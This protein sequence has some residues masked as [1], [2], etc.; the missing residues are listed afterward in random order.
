MARLPIPGSDD[1]TW[2]AILNDYLTVAHDADGTLKASAVSTKANDSAVV[3]TTGDETI[4]GVKTFS[5]SP[6]VPTP[7][8]GTEAT[9]KT[10][11]DGLISSGAPDATSS[12]KGIL[13]LT[14]DLGGT[15][16]S[17]TVPGLAGKEATISAG[18]TSQYWR[19]DKSWQ[20]LDKTAVGLA[21]ADNTSDANKPVSTAT[22]TALNA[23]ADTSAVIPLS[24]ATTKGDLLAATA[25][26]TI[27]RLGVGANGQVL[28]ADSTQTTG[29]RWAT[30]DG[31]A[32]G[33]A[34]TPGAAATVGTS[35][36]QIVAANASRQELYIYNNHATNIVYLSLGGTAVVGQGARINPNGDYFYT[37]SY[38]G[39]VSAIATGASTGVGITEV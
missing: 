38:T 21:N 19:G 3:H 31:V 39:A 33:T 6:I 37:T 24:T 23:K 29:L 14:G 1:G 15:A 27:T 11:V 28:S 25:A 17:P 2:G 20:T 26:A 22:Q 36:G 9:N 12:T 18:T 7:T 34:A 5:S 10:Y 13:Q 8:T 32:L 4:A 35:S 30:V 16:V